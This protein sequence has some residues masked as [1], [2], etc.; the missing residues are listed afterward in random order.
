MRVLPRVRSPPGRQVGLNDK[1]NAIETWSSQLA[2][3]LSVAGAAVGLGTLWRFPFL[4]GQYGGGLFVLVFVVVCVLIA[5]PLLVAEF[6]LGRRGGENVPSA[7][8]RVAVAAGRSRRWSVV[9]QLGTIAVFVI[10]TYYS[11]IG[12]WVLS[13][14]EA[15]AVGEVATLDHAALTARFAATAGEPVAARVLARALHGDYGADLAGG[16][17]RGIEIGNKIMLP[18]LFV[19]LAGLAV[20]ALAHGDA[21][22]GLAFLTSL[23]WRRFDAARSCWRPSA[24]RFT[25]PVSAWRS[26]LS[27]AAAS[28]ANRCHVPPP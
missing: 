21:A 1:S 9:G 13:Y 25:R 5:V 17:H 3:Y 16:L 15:Y 23:D 4:V 6:M 12:G 2:F 19:I 10:M 7:A 24:R 28:P 14:V 11:V 8:G 22:R 20:Y 18:A 27:T 26:S